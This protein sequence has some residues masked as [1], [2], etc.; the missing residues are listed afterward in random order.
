[1][2]RERQRYARASFACTVLKI[3]SC[4]RADSESVRILAQA[5]SDLLKQT[6]IEQTRIVSGYLLNCLS[7]MAGDFRW[8][9]AHAR[10]NSHRFDA[11]ARARARKRAKEHAHARVHLNAEALASA[12]ARAGTDTAH[13]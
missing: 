7:V 2:G 5:D 6:W 12:R 1:M 8:S 13:A 10:T 11:L 4:M 3:S 9:T